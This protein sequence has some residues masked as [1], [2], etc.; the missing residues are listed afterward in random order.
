MDI[1]LDIDE[2]VGPNKVYKLKKTMYEFKQLPN[3]VWQVKK[4]DDKSGI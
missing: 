1:I 2:E 3:R 4:D